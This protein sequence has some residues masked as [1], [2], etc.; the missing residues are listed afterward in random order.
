MPKDNS[1]TVGRTPSSPFHT[2]LRLTGIKIIFPGCGAGAAS[3]RQAQPQSQ[4]V[5]RAI[6]GITITILLK[7]N[8]LESPRRCK[9]FWPF[10]SQTYSYYYYYYYYYYYHYSYYNY[11]YYYH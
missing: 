1:L 2:R 10:S 8:G 11:Y 4:G 5:H 3:Q 7:Q 9:D 6:A